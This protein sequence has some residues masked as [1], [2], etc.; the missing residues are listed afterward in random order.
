MAIATQNNILNIQS[1]SVPV[2]VHLSQGDVG[3]TLGFYIYNGSEPVLMDGFQVSVHGIR[4]DGVGFGPYTVTTRANSNYVTFGIRSVMAAVMGAALAELTITNGSGA[5]VGTA[6]FAMLVEQGTFPDGPVYSTDI[7]VYQ[8]I[9]NYVQT[10]PANVRSDY[11]S[12]IATVQNGLD[13]ETAARQT[14]DNTLQSNINAEASTRATTDASLQSQIDQ[15][16]APSGEAP[17]AAEVQNARIGADGV[18]YP[19]LG[20]AIRTNDSE[21]K[22]QIGG[23][24]VPLTLVATYTG[25]L[26]RKTGLEDN[27]SFIT[28]QYAIPEECSLVHIKSN[29]YG[30]TFIIFTDRATDGDFSA[31]QY[32]AYPSS[33]YSN[34]TT[35][36]DDYDSKGFKYVWFPLYTTSGVTASASASYKNI[37]DAVVQNA[38][39]SEAINDSLLDLNQAEPNRIYVFTVNIANVQN[40]PPIPNGG[41]LLCYSAYGVDKVQLFI[42]SQNAVYFRRLWGTTWGAWK[43][44]QTEDTVQSIVE[45]AVSTAIA[46]YYP[47][48]ILSAFKNITCI[49]DSLT[50]SQVYTS[51]TTSRQAYKPYPKVIADRAGATETIL[52]MAGDSASQAWNRNGENIVQKDA[53]LTL[54]YLGTN[55]GL[56]DT[57]DTDMVGNDYTQ[58]ANTN[59]GC[60]GKIIAKSIA[61]GSRVVLIKVHSSSG[62]VAVTNTVIEKMATRFGVPFIENIYLSGVKYHSFPD[63]SGTEGTHYNDFGYSVFADQVANSISHLSPTDAVKI[64]PA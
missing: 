29:F 60:Y 6:N 63:G 62:G 50:A 49:G 52:A 14:A 5:S 38:V 3:N 51:A 11:I 47:Y 8:Q 10:I 26:L 57:M 54:V 23:L 30:N 1:G 56:T 28:Y 64:I 19:T 9:L 59:T 21:L 32:Q 44:I 2:T 41:T 58:W 42:S 39:L 25:K 33:G 37:V 18:T 35:V 34:P 43:Q 17:S 15:L 48:N 46:D 31:S 16:I 55:G 24:Y 22:S 45:T 7:S 4:S 27:S 53:Q 13:A 36:D 61:V 20:D 12:R 40:Y